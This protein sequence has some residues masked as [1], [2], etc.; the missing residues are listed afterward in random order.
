MRTLLR[1]WDSWLLWALLASIGLA[2]AGALGAT[3]DAVTR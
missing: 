3:L 2:A 1:D